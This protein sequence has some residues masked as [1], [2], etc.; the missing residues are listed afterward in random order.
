MS[1]VENIY[2]LWKKFSLSDCE[3][4]KFLLQESVVKEE[5]FVAARF[6][7]WRVLSMEAIARTFKLLWSTHKGFEVKDIGNHKSGV[8]LF[9]CL[10]CGKGYDG[11]TMDVQ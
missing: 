8:R 3:G 10:G 5:F 7:R 6:F 11:G 2:V 4:Q 9:G 1:I